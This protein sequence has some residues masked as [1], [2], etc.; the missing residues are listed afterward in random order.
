VGLVGE[1][2][3]RAAD[4]HTSRS[5]GSSRAPSSMKMT[6]GIDLWERQLS[7]ESRKHPGGS[8]RKGHVYSPRNTVVLE[9]G[10]Q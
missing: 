7:D 10:I 6:G 3:N 4:E 2:G 8:Q 5:P 9:G 1:H